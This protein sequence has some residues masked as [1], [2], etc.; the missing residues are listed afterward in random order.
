MRILSVTSEYNPGTQELDGV[1]VYCNDGRY[2]PLTENQLAI[3]NQLQMEI[4]SSLTSALSTDEVL[5]PTNTTATS[6]HCN[7]TES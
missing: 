1:F 5:S 4:H 6:T 2:I 7:P 3:W